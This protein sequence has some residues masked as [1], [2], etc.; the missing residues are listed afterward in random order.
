MG[1][2]TEVLNDEGPFGVRLCDDMLNVFCDRVQMVAPR[3]VNGFF[4]IQSILCDPTLQ[5]QIKPG[6]EVIQII[7]DQYRQHYITVYLTFEDGEPL[8]R[9]YDPL[10]NEASMKDRFLKETITSSVVR[11][12][13]DLFGHLDCQEGRSEVF[14]EHVYDI[15]P[16]MDGWSCGYRC[17]G[18][19]LD[20]LQNRDPSSSLYDIRTIYNLYQ[21]VNQPG[22]HSWEDIIS[23]PYRSKRCKTGARPGFLCLN[24]DVFESIRDQE[25]EEEKRAFKEKIDRSYL[26]TS[27]RFV[28]KHQGSIEAL[29]AGTIRVSDD[30]YRQ[31]SFSSAKSSCSLSVNN[32]AS[33]I[34]SPSTGSALSR[35]ASAT[36]DWEKLVRRELDD[37]VDWDRIENEKKRWEWTKEDQDEDQEL[38]Q[39]LLLQRVNRA[40][41]L[42]YNHRVTTV[43]Q[44]ALW[45]P[46]YHL[47]RKMKIPELADRNGANVLDGFDRLS[48]Q[49]RT[50]SEDERNAADHEES[51][52]LTSGNPDH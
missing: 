49:Q 1:C 38:Q 34:S 3:Q 31:L 33:E 44:T 22:E 4:A 46:R 39:M 29:C 10:L 11:Q 27:A 47:I 17:I 51:S 2:S 9:V 19:I 16:Q 35:S 14:V 45:D 28:F 26:L 24:E 13:L 32:D 42:E 8:L 20:L 18:V 12:I 5:A 40:R 6:D 7:F 36:I 50:K 37:P 15:D 21:W 41:L 43:K 23:F 52:T 48:V 30:G 25:I